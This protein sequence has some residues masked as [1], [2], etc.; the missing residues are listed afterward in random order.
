M[1]KG[2]I[3]Y[4]AFM[5]DRLDLIQKKVS[6][7]PVGNRFTLQGASSSGIQLQRASGCSNP[8]DWEPGVLVHHYRQLVVPADLWI[9]VIYNMQTKGR[10]A[11]SGID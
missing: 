3:Q 8:V 4:T 11:S 7:I 6:G 5:V 9:K 2:D 1:D 10:Q